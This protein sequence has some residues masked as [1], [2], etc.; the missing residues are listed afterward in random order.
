M[1]P[2]TSAS[3]RP[4]TA[5]PG[6]KRS[7]CR[8]SFESEGRSCGVHASA[9]PIE[10]TIVKALE[11]IGSIASHMRKPQHIPHERSW[12][13]SCDTLPGYLPVGH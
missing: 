4:G 13:K 3:A 11:K 2:T 1:A 8:R 7:A 5:W 6:C 12:A 10:Q 9:K